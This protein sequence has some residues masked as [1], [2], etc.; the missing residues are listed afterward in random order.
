MKKFNNKSYETL[1]ND[2]IGD[3]F[4]C[5]ISYRGRVAKIRQYTEVIVRKLIDYDPNKGI[6]LGKHCIEKRIHSIPNYCFI[7]DSLENIRN[8]GNDDSHTQKRDVVTEDE[9]NRVVDSLFNMLSILL[10]NYFDKYKFGS[11]EEV[12]FSFSLLPPIIRYK[13]LSYLYEKDS[14]NISVIDK[15]VLS[16][17][18]AYDIDT[19]KKWIEKEKENLILKKAITDNAYNDLIE[20]K[21]I[22]RA[23]YIYENIILN[24]YESCKQKILT[25][26]KNN[27][28]KNKLYLDFESALPYYKENGVLSK[29]DE[30]SNEFN[31][32]MYFLYMGRKEQIKKE[33]S[34][35][36]LDSY[37]E[38]DK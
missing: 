11:N 34:F 18:K 2:L 25:F 15:L 13:V 5:G 26:E 23:S 9:Y 36:V 12:M 31:D 3:T 4:Y 38:D 20:K 19:A 32:I 1:V 28:E 35:N 17:M 6:T 22:V 16:I 7:K 30:E 10:I 37:V 33:L 27:M 21:G 14:E 8:Y 29:G 24:M